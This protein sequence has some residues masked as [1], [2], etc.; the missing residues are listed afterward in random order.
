MDFELTSAQKTDRAAFRDFVDRAVA[1]D[2]GRYD[3]E[4][5]IPCSL[6]AELARAGYLGLWLPTAFAGQGKDMLTYGLLNE[7]LGRGCS[8]VRS[9]VTVHGMVSHAVARWGT[10]AQ[11]DHW[12]PELAKGH[13]VGAFALTEPQAGSDAQAINSTAEFVRREYKLNGVKRWISFGQIATLFLVFARTEGKPAAFLVER[14]TPGLSVNPIHGMLG[15]RASMLAELRLDDCAVPKDNLLGA[16]GCGVSH[17]ASAALDHGRY[18]VACGCVGIAQ[19]ALEAVQG[20]VDNR[21]Q[22][23]SLLKQH[24]LI[25]RMVSNMV[26]NVRAA[27]LLCYRAGWLKDTGDP[28]AIGETWIAKYFASRTATRTTIDAVQ[29]HGANGCS[30]EYPV[31]RYM[32]DARIME[33]IEGSTE[34]Q[35]LTIA[36]CIEACGSA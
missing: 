10:Q 27:R 15:V 8:S 9:L 17:V 3:R 5:R 21:K 19:A 29:I 20:Y 1:P 28:R 6:I 16:A 23:G 26:T 18:S 22:F 4:E 32:R 31:E 35:Q 13:I 2:A 33:I 24:Q 14:N 30:C 11:R 12:L 36:D 7:E 34:I 25:R